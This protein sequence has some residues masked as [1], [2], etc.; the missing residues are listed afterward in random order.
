MPSG[1]FAQDITGQQFN[2]WTV[3]GR[4]GTME[5]KAKKAL[6]HC[7]CK[8]GTERILTGGDLRNGHSK[9]CG[10]YQKEVASKVNSTH[11]MGRSKE[12]AAWSAMMTRCTNSNAV[13]YADYGG[14]GIKVCDRWK[15]FENFYADMGDANGLTLDRV[16]V[17]GDYEPNNCR[18]ATRK[19]Q[20][21]NKR[22]NVVIE[23]SGERM[24]A[25]QW[26][27][28]TGI[29]EGTI[30]KRIRLGWPVERVLTE[31]PVIGRNQTWSKAA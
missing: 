10:C 18:W 23:F 25:M 24:T 2:Y 11:G 12:Y 13:N 5:G 30:R 20:G 26:S 9:S 8:C 21:N 27:E 7:A 16:D 22:N 19:E 14:R 6:W 3:S 4:A 29:G 31:K 28:R 1:R 17:N 15:A